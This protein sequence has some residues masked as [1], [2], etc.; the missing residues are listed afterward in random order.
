MRITYQ[1]RRKVF[2]STSLRVLQCLLN[3]LAE[4]VFLDSE[5]KRWS[6]RRNSQ[7]HVR[8]PR[9]RP[10]EKHKMGHTQGPSHREIIP[11]PIRSPLLQPR[12]SPRLHHQSYILDQLAYTRSHLASANANNHALRRAI[13]LVRSDGLVLAALGPDMSALLGAFMCH[14]CVVL[15]AGKVAVGVMKSQE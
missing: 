14:L 4:R 10:R 6:S 9:L 15:Q 11:Q 5:V 8:V 13:D 3:I 7:A 2:L 1:R 12:S